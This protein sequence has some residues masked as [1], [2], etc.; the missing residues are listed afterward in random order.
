[1][2]ATFNTDVQLLENYRK[3]R[4][5]NNPTG[6]ACV[7]LYNNG[8]VTTGMSEIARFETANDAAKA[9]KAA[10]YRKGDGDKHSTVYYV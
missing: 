7:Q 5:A 4:A 1:M 10:G 9:L 8:S 6:M 3:H 2:T